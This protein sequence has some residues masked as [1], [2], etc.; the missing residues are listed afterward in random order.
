V[1][2]EQDHAVT[3]QELACLV[4]L[5]PLDPPEEPLGEIVTVGDR[6]QPRVDAEVDRL[7]RVVGVRQGDDPPD[8]QPFVLVL[9]QRP[10]PALF[11]RQE[12]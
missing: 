10:L 12:P 5:D 3:L 8:V 2:I 6:R 4:R 7:A 1:R 9:E 11:V